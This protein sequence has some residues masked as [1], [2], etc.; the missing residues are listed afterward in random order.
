MSLLHLEMFIFA[1]V[2]KIYS[3]LFISNLKG[4]QIKN[5]IPNLHY[6]MQIMLKNLIKKMI[7]VYYYLE[8]KMISKMFQ[9]LQEELVQEEQEEQKEEPE[10][11]EELVY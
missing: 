8:D 4:Q 2:I 10:V 7:D 9:L 1:N 3:Q 6:T 11:L 5:L